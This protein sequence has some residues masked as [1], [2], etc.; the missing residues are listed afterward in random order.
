MGVVPDA[1][2]QRGPGALN[3]EVRWEELRL[4]VPE[5]CAGKR[6]VLDLRTKGVEVSDAK[7]ASEVGGA[8]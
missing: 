4:E 8:R 2:Q 6:L 3:R 7:G 1:E 5:G